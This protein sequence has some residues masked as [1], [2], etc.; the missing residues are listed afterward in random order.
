VSQSRATWYTVRWLGQPVVSLRCPV[1]QR[2]LCILCA[3]SSVAG[4]GTVRCHQRSSMSD[5]D[6]DGA[7]VEVTGTEARTQAR[8]RA[9]QELKSRSTCVRC[10]CSCWVSSGSMVVSCIV[11]RGCVFR[12]KKRRRRAA[13]A[14]TDASDSEPEQT[15]G[16]PEEL[17][18]QPAGHKQRCHTHHPAVLRA[19]ATPPRS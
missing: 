15:V 14:P 6:S 4:R 11:R 18:V 3:R 7:P 5:S 12:Q 1:H 17:A 19:T 8:N 10:G 16:N 2:N 13:K 9:A